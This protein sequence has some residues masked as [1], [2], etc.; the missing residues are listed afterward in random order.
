MESEASPSRMHILDFHQLREVDGRTPTWLRC[1]A[2]FMLEV[3][4]FSHFL[5][6]RKFQVP[7]PILDDNRST[8]CRSQAIRQGN[9]SGDTEGVVVKETVG[10]S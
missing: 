7:V 4:S 6:S 1:L 10:T 9:L 2:V 5:C 8:N 3:A